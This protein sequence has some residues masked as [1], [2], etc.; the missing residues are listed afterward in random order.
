MET[1][2]AANDEEESAIHSVVASEVHLHGPTSNTVQID[3]KMF[4]SRFLS[5]FLPLCS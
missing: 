1:E 3:C 4:S 5:Y 2:N